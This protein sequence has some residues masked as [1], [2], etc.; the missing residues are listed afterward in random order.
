MKSLSASKYNHNNTSFT[1]PDKKLNKIKYTVYY[2]VK[3]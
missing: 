2:E 3:W 1:T